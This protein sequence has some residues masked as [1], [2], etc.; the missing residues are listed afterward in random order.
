[1]DQGLEKLHW[2]LAN[3]D[4]K[5]LI[6]IRDSDCRYD[7]IEG[8][9]E[10]TFGFSTPELE[11]IFINLELEPQALLE[12]GRVEPHKEIENDIWD[13][14]KQAKERNNNLC[15]LILA[16][17]ERGKTTL[18]RHL[19]Y[20][21]SIKRPEKGAPA[22]IPVLL[23]L[24]RLQEV[25]AKTE[26][27]DLPS[28]I[29]KHI[30]QDI[31]RNLNLPKNWAKNHLSQNKMLIMFDGFDEI[32]PEHTDKISQWIGKQ[33]HDFRENYFI[34]TSRPKGYEAFRSEHR[35]RKTVFINEFTNKNI[36]D[37]VYKWYFSQE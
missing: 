1:M 5:Y 27:L 11:Q 32:K 29:E 21:Y 10:T 25:I 30:K 18:L 31:S 20:K 33:W 17:G 37:F 4:G 15:L 36:K 8:I 16:P 22:L 6:K 13:V 34:L 19:A 26:E 24:R 14:L 2:K 35:P 12:T 9:E 28:L 7:D 23:R 3:H